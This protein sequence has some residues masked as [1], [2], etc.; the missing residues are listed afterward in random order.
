MWVCRAVYV[1]F[2]LSLFPQSLPLTLLFMSPLLLSFSLSHFYM[3]LLSLFLSRTVFSAYLFFSL[4]IACLSLPVCL[5]LSLLIS[6]SLSSSLWSYACHPVFPDLASLPSV[7]LASHSYNL[8]FV[9]LSYTISLSHLSVC[10]FLSTLY[11]SVYLSLPLT[12]AAVSLICLHVSRRLSI[13][14]SILA[15]CSPLS[16]HY[17]PFTELNFPFSL[18]GPPNKWHQNKMVERRLA[19][20]LR[21]DR[22]ATTAS[23]AG[24]THRHPIVK[25]RK[26][27]KE[28]YLMHRK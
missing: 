25:R 23:S 19:P 20:R 22:T 13:T 21:G 7:C 12:L 5:S 14:V 1:C 2:F 18:S 11:H 10:L 17:R 16:S 28:N 8:L 27:R 9:W 3:V 4:D 6:L 24:C 26:K 15:L